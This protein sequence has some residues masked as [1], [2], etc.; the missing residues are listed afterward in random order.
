LSIYI[1]SENKV[2]NAFVGSPCDRFCIK[3]LQS[4]VK[5]E[6]QRLSLWFRIV[7]RYQRGDRPCPEVSPIRG[8]RGRF[9]ASLLTSNAVLVVMENKSIKYW[10]IRDHGSHLEYIGT[11]Y[12]EVKLA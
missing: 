2:K 5:G 12:S 8:Y 7:R 4:R 1:V 6:Q 9:L 10:P 11:V 3:F